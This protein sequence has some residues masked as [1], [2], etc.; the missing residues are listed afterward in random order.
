MKEKR[1]A[2]G[3][4]RKIFWNVRTSFMGKDFLKLIPGT[5]FYFPVL[6]GIPAYTLNLMQTGNIL[7]DIII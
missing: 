1:M 7:P 6:V 2:P 3:N 5:F 4:F